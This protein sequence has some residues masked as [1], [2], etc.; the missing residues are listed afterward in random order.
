V[1]RFSLSCSN[2][3]HKAWTKELSSA[4][5]LAL[6]RAYVDRALAEDAT[7]VQSQWM[8]TVRQA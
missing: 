5:V 1:H 7:A 3:S 6:I 4:D 2:A 8:L